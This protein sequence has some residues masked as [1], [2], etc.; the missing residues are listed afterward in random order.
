MS[1]WT[2]RKGYPYLTILDEKW[3]T[4]AVEFTLEQNWFLA[5]GSGMEAS[6]EEGEA[7][8]SIPLLFST[9]KQVSESAVLMTKKIQTFSVPLTHAEDWVKINSGQKAL[10]RV[11]HSAEMTRRLAPSL[12]DKTLSPVDRAALLLDAYALAKAGLAP[13]ESAVAILHNLANEDSSIVWGELTFIV[14]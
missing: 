8:W 2:K 1:T 11:A 9:S 5:D 12:R 3:S 10:A 4:T 14:M 13:I 6:K 7:L